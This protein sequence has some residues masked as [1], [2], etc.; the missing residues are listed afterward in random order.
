MSPSEWDFIRTPARGVFALSFH[1][2]LITVKPR[3]AD[4][5]IQIATISV[6]NG[7]NRDDKC[8]KWL[9]S[10]EFDDGRGLQALGFLY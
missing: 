3:K 5:S 7:A 6:R 4:I 9:K 1:S 10:S 2:Q 8:Q